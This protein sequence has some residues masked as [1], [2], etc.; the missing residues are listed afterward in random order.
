MTAYFKKHLG[1]GRFKFHWQIREE[2]EVRYF[3]P[4]SCNLI[5]YDCV[6]KNSRLAAQKIHAG[7]NRQPVAKIQ[8]ES[9]EVNPH[10]PTQDYLLL[11][12]IAYD[13][14]VQPYFRDRYGNNIDGLKI[15]K[16]I[17]VGNQVF[18]AIPRVNSTP[19]YTD[20][21][22]VHFVKEQ[23]KV[24]LKKMNI[25]VKQFLELVWFFPWM[26]PSDSLTIEINDDQLSWQL[27]SQRLRQ[28]LVSR[29]TSD[30]NFGAYYTGEIEYDELKYLLD[31]IYNLIDREN[32]R[33][34]QKILQE[35]LEVE[36][37]ESNSLLN[38][39][40]FGEICQSYF[41]KA[42]VENYTFQPMA[43][44]GAEDW[45]LL[46]NLVWYLTKEQ[47][48]LIPL[49]SSLEE[50][51]VVDFST[52]GSKLFVSGHSSQ[53]LIKAN[54]PNYASHELNEPL[55]VPWS[56][57]IATGRK[58]IELS[59]E[60]SCSP[61]NNL[62][63]I[64]TGNQ[65][66]ITE[67]KPLSTQ[68]NSKASTFFQRHLTLA[69][70][71]LEDDL[72]LNKWL[73]RDKFQLAQQEPT[74]V[75]KPISVRGESRG[76]ILDIAYLRSRNQVQSN[77]ILGLE[78]EL[79]DRNLDCQTISEAKKIFSSYTDLS[80]NWV[81]KLAQLIGTKVD[82]FASNFQTVSDRFEELDPKNKARFKQIRESVAELIQNIRDLTCNQ[83]YLGLSGFSILLD[84]PVY[85]SQVQEL[86]NYN[87]TI[88]LCLAQL[89]N[90]PLIYK[91]HQK[92]K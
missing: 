32:G 37:D 2:G 75:E 1:N 31:F 45:N 3:D 36:F 5:L 52:I 91:V 7:A 8:A 11:K 18:Q 89:N 6:L 80:Y 57:I 42:E 47:N 22:C 14:R 62:L 67:V 56:A 33:I 43:K 68:N 72:P 48:S 19:P 26:N 4:N 74:I 78:Y 24:I 86:V 76:T 81:D 54:F 17:T 84:R 49:S 77:N 60:I 92:I 29:Y 20:G 35:K 53:S 55:Q 41:P 58:P 10:D 63:Q 69:F 88:L 65:S 82:L 61:E 44:I 73:K 46:V 79:V 27:T 90:Q 40:L 9:Y 70:Q 21:A 66:I 12:P 50:S 51:N 23:T 71:K 85:F 38:F 25:T 34:S 83:F 30:K 87:K 16:I 64:D 28:S 59:V 13:P 39:Y 15:K